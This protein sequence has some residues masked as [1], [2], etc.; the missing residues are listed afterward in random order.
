MNF[1]YRVSVILWTDC[2]SIHSYKWQT[3]GGFSSKL[4]SNWELAFTVR[5]TVP[6]GTELI[7]PLLL[8]KILGIFCG[9]L[10]RLELKEATHT[11]NLRQAARNHHIITPRHHD[12][13][14]LTDYTAHVQW[15]HTP[16]SS[17]LSQFI[18]FSHSFRSEHAETF[19]LL[20]PCLL[21]SLQ[22][23]LSYGIEIIRQF[24]EPE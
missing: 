15:R 10:T 12:N 23:F 19:W 8:L 7:I 4:A 21:F 1:F 20:L 3:I 18:S 16:V 9:Q 6:N 11:G 17:K 22:F 24:T 2:R 14:M 5:V 13:T